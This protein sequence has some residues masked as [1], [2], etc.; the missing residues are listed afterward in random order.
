[1]KIVPHIF[2]NELRGLLG[3]FWKK[4][5][6]RRVEKVKEDLKA[7]RITIDEFGIAYNSLGRVVMSD[8]AEII[9]YVTPQIELDATE[10]ARKLEVQ[11]S[12]RDY[13]SMR[14]PELLAEIRSEFGAG[15]TVVDV[16]NGETYR[17]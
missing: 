10:Q 11:M 2:E 4:D 15:H 8:L 7:G 3:D 17:L 9:H 16:I 14:S 12:L 1:M 13:T 6:E 5:A